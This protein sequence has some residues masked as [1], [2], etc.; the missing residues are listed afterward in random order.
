MI[1]CR[2]RYGSPQS[3]ALIERWLGILR[4]AAY[5]ESAQLAAEKGAFPLFD[6]EAYLDRP[7]IRSLPETIR[8][9]IAQTGIRNALLTSIAP[10][11][12]ISLFAGNISSGIEPVFA[13]SFRRNVLM[14]DGVQREEQITDFS[15]RAFRGAFGEE[16]ELPDY[17]VSA[18]ELLP[19]E[20][21]AVQ[22]AAQKYIDSSISKTINCSAAIPFDEFK[23]IYRRAYCEGCKG[24]TTYRPNPV[25]GAI[26]QTDAA[27]PAQVVKSSRA[28]PTARADHPASG[29]VVYMTKPLDRPGDLSGHTY[30]VR[31]PDLDHAFYITINDIE[32]DGRKRPFEI[33][34]NSKNMEHYAWTV[35]LTR[36]ISAV[37]R[38]GGDITFVVDE[39]KAVFDPRGGQWMAGRYVPSLL[40]AI[41]EV[42]ERHL[43]AIGFIPGEDAAVGDARRIA[44]AG[45]ESR[46]RTCPRCS[47]A[48]LAKIEGCDTCLSCGYSKCA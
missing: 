3:L 1:F 26:L 39:L 40:A 16:T 18:H 23:D 8:E 44:I 28:Q 35:A 10:T 27:E 34:I 11:G 20:H 7:I 14:P 19:S 29:S 47:A 37:F 9:K 4:N 13:N 5:D 45:D 15:Y 42:I 24:C 43:V 12:T 48:A 32:Q 25:T 21:L 33:F 17:F 31:W 38:R 6:R 22:A 2:T 46:F 41:G 30:K 36:M